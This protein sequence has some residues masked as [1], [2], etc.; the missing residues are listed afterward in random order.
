MRSQMLLIIVFLATVS[1]GAQAAPE[2][3]P[4]DADKYREM[5]VIETDALLT[6]EI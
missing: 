3:L 5:I 1:F 2:F 6:G 4:L